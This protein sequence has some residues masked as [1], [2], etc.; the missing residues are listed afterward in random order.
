[1]TSPQKGKKA[2]IIRS[3]NRLKEMAQGGARGES[4]VDPALLDKAMAEVQ[5]ATEDFSAIAA[6]TITAMREDLA[7]AQ[8]A[9]ERATHVKRIQGQAHELR[10]QGGTFGYPLVSRVAK[11]LYQYTG[12]RRDASDSHL[13]VIKAHIDTL[14]ALL[15]HKVDGDGGEIGRQLI[16][17][18]KAAITKHDRR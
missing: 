14:A 12:A 7:N 3:R 15:H 1:M 13:T 10:N 9:A 11:S 18:L 4:G 2:Y 16:D 6:E 8:E 17:A 5:S